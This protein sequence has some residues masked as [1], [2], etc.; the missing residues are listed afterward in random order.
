MD[1]RRSKFYQMIGIL[2]HKAK[3]C[4]KQRKIFFTEDSNQVTHAVQMD[5]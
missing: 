4:I 5:L 3:R 1:L 2:G